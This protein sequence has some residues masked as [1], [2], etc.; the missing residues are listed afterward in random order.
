[1][2]K[3]FS[4]KISVMMVIITTSFFFTCW[5][6]LALAS[7][8]EFIKPTLENSNQRLPISVPQRGIT[9]L[10]FIEPI[11]INSIY[12]SHGS[13]SSTPARNGTMKV[14]NSLNE[15]IGSIG[16]GP[17]N[18]G[19]H[20]EGRVFDYKDV[21]KIEFSSMFNVSSF[22]IT[23][24]NIGVF[25]VH[26][27]ISNLKASVE[28]RSVKLSWE[29][30]LNN[31]EFVGVRIYRNEDMIKEL[32]RE[33]SY[34]DA[35]EN[36]D[37]EYVYR[38][39]ALY[40][41][42]HETA[43]KSVTVKA[44]K[45]PPIP[46]PAG[47]IEEL[48]AKVTHE[49][50]DL[51]WQLPNSD[52]FE[53]VIIYR[54]TLKKNLFDKLLGVTTVKA[55]ATPIFETNGTYFNDLTVQPETKYEY[56]LTTMSTEKVESDGVSVV[57]TTPKEPDP[58]IEG[59]GYEKDPTTGDYTFTWSKPTEGEVKVIVGGKLYK[60]VPAAD[61]KIVIPAADMKFTFLGKPDVQL[62]PVSPDGNEGKPVSPPSGGSNGGGNGGGSSGAEM[63]FKANDLVMTTF[64]II[65]LL[66]GI[67]LIVLAIQLAPRI[68][69]VIKQSIKN[70]GMV[71]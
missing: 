26:Q 54:D 35:M 53:H 49:R 66:S 19:G 18:P 15:E 38:V 60:T 55:A 10:I 2:D 57:V 42:G 8:T 16:F 50:V 3:F 28:D 14:F 11:N 13:W 64:Q 22:S 29:S 27:N 6:Q 23:E 68:I 46:E 58:E 17:G 39:T 45:P 51:S 61:G 48:K 31:T 7:E 43:G 69:A 44:L 63:P 62:I 67:L 30:L 56:T 1:M 41:G 59:G 52:K 36:Y 65:G 34:I 25:D 20:L 4:R 70:R 9:A 5:S 71:K 12:V 37:E 33:S 21:K 40:R 24:F 32:G 47:E